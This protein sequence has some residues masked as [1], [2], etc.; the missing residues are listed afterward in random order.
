M[1]DNNNACHKGVTT[2]GGHKQRTE[3]NPPYLSCH[4]TFNFFRLFNVMMRNQIE[5]FNLCTVGSLQFY[6]CVVSREINRKVGQS[7]ARM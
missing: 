7:N 3:E 1:C 4:Y 2:P 6:D 5:N